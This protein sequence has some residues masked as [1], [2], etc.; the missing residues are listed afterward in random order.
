MPPFVGNAPP[1]KKKTEKEAASERQ[2]AA[3]T[4]PSNFVPLKI[5]DGDDKVGW[6]EW[7]YQQSEVA[8]NREVTAY[9]HL[10][11]LQGNRILECF[12][13]GTLNLTG[14]AIAPRVLLLEYLPHAQTLKAISASLITQPIIDSLITTATSFGP[15]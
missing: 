7:Y 13:S 10:T 6:E 14:R 5:P 1:K 9:W 4:Q 8:A 15:L 12:G 11:P 3:P 2:R